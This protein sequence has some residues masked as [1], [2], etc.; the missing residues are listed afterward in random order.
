[1]TQIHWNQFY[2]DVEANDNCVVQRPVFVGFEFKGYEVVKQPIF[3]P[4]DVFL[5][6]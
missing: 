3:D 5:S 6:V 4:R 2:P 1:M